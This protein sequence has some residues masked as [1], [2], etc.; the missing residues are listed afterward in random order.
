MGTRKMERKV[1]DNTDLKKKY[2]KLKKEIERHNKL[3][4]QDNKPK[5]SDIEYDRI[6]KQLKEIEI[7]YP[8]LKTTDSPI[9]KIGYAPSKN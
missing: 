4:Y 6:W 7:E 1:E 2:S 8:N 3:Y 9:S 5:I